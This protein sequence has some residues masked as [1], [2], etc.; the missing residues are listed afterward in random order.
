MIISIDEEKALAKIQHPFLIK[1]FNKLGIE[2]SFLDLK[3]S[4]CEEP[5]ANIIFNSE[6]KRAFPLRS[7]TR[8]QCLLL[9]LLFN[10]VLEILVSTIRQ[11]NEIK[12]IQIGKKEVKLYLLM[13]DLIYRKP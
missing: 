13:N 9:S 8:Q 2:R 12:G 1:K 11:E 10:I 6:R 4:I 5:I 7:G 3:K